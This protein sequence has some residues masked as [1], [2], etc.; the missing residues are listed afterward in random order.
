[1]S[2]ITG[3]ELRKNIKSKINAIIDDDII[4]ENIEKGIYNFTIKQATNKSVLKKWD[5]QKFRRM[6]INKSRSV[7]S[8]I[9]SNSYVG[10]KRLLDRLKSGEFL[11]H[12]IA[13]MDKQRLFPENWK[14]L[15]DEKY[16]RDRILYEIDQG[17][18]TDEFKCSRCK[19]RKCTYYELQTRSADEP[20][21]VFLTCLN[22]G[23]RWRT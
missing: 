12:E 2:L 13:F 7:Y 23:K 14:E 15:I 17:G 9:D 6:Y 21:T 22:C 1:M 11:P 3:Y 16:K 8:N 5:N 4:S 18:A 20:M 19:Q 10:N